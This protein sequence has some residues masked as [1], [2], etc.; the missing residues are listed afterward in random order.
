M[1]DAT[2]TTIKVIENV[3]VLEVENILKGWPTYVINFTPE[4]T[5][6]HVRISTHIATHHLM[7]V[8]QKIILHL[9]KPSNCITLG[10]ED[11]D[12]EFISCPSEYGKSHCAYM[13]L[14]LSLGPEAL[15]QNCDANIM[16]SEPR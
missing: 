15:M 6:P 16:V 10:P 14:F 4:S 1:S 5:R 8:L 11:D 7:L 12:S 9:Q 3:I 13:H 2:N